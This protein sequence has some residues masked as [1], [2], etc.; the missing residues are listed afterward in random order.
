MPSP[1][2]SYGSY[3]VCWPSWAPFTGQETRDRDLYKNGYE[4]E[5]QFAIFW[6]PDYE[7][8]VLGLPILMP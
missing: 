7:F 8:H 5:L 3:K 6:I 4:Q 1:F 2:E